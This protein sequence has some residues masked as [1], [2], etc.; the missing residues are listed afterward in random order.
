MTAQ[1]LADSCQAQNK[2]ADA[3][4]GLAKAVFVNLVPVASTH[5]QV[6]LEILI[7]IAACRAGASHVL[8]VDIDPFAC[9]A[10]RLNMESAGVSFEVSR[11]SIQRSPTLD[12]ATAFVSPANSPARSTSMTISTVATPLSPPSEASTVA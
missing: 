9:T 6:F 2:V 1:S 3:N 12:A 7:R 5:H 8:A 11:V 4:R 10:A